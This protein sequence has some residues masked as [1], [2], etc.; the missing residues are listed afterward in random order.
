MPIGVLDRG[1]A[2]VHLLEAPLERRVLLDVLAELV[3]G[4]GADHAQ[5]AAGQH[6][7]DHVAGVHRP[8]GTA[9]ADDRVHLVDEGDH[10]ALGVGDLLEDG[11]ESFLEL[12]AVLGAREHRRDVERDQPLALQALGHVAVADAAGEPLDDRGLADPGLAD[13][14][15]VVLGAA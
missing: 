1:L 12:A 8:L 11:L 10:L 3:E 14:H 13:E 7:L 2:H 9:G 15:R 4:G 6:R 5:L